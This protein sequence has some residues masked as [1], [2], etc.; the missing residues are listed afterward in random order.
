NAAKLSRSVEVTICAPGMK[1]GTHLLTTDGEFRA[2]YYPG[3]HPFCGPFAARNELGPDIP[4]IQIIGVGSTGG[5]RPWAD[6]LPRD[7]TIPIAGWKSRQ[8]D[9]AFMLRRRA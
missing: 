5:G 6:H 9:L 8:T 3:S 1:P 4:L 2:K 7:D